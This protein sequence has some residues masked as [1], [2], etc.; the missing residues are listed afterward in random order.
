MSNLDT[1]VA[2]SL[3]PEWRTVTST[4]ELFKCEYT[5]LDLALCLSVFCWD[6]S[7][8]LGR[9]QNFDFSIPMFLMLSM[10]FPSFSALFH[11]E[12]NLATPGPRA[13]PC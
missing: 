4:R 9:Q 13:L 6:H 3:S 11:L 2:W 5:H 7:Q 10:L 1:M 8:R 12:W